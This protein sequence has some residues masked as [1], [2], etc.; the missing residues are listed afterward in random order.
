MNRVYFKD[1]YSY[2][3][4]RKDTSFDV[5]SYSSTFVKNLTFNCIVKTSYKHVYG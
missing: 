3:D 4:N 5:V 2:L 1:V